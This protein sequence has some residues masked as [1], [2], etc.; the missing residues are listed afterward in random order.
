MANLKHLRIGP[1]WIIWN[2]LLLFVDLWYSREISI[3]FRL[4]LF[5]DVGTS[6]MRV[7][8]V[9][10]LSRL[11]LLL[12]QEVN[13]FVLSFSFVYSIF[14][15]FKRKLLLKKYKLGEKVG[16]MESKLKMYILKKNNFNSSENNFGTYYYSFSFCFL[17]SFMQGKILKKM[18]V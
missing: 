17:F 5:L 6:Y 14:Y 2:A 3:F 10:H 4:W 13:Y 9:F 11:L 18:P 15:L 1:H 16:V 8:S 7:N 12:H